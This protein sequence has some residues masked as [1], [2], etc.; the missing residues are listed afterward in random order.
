MVLTWIYKNKGGLTALMY[1]CEFGFVEIVKILVDAGANLNLQNKED[2]TALMIACYKN[3]ECALELIRNGANLNLQN[4]HGKTALIIACENKLESVVD[5][6]IKFGADVNL[7]DKQGVSALIAASWSRSKNI[8]NNLIDHGANIDI[9]VNGFTCL[10]SCCTLELQDIALKLINLGATL[11]FRNNNGW[12]ALMFAC[13]YRVEMIATILIEKKVD[14]NCESFNIVR[15]VDE[16]IIKHRFDK[17]ALHLVCENK[18]QSLAI[19]LINA[20]AELYLLDLDKRSPIDFILQNKLTDV[21]NH[22]K[23]MYRNSLLENM[24]IKLLFTIVS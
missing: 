16:G 11:T 12:S 15:Y 10:M 18:M 23:I 17:T 1:V 22:L 5:E 20:G 6:L 9:Q 4:Q 13:D 14:V 8:I 2:N 7:L 19:K 3:S 24:I 21:I